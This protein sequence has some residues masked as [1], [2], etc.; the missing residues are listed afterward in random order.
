MPARVNSNQISEV[1]FSK[2][3]KQSSWVFVLPG[4]EFL[5]T[6]VEVYSTGGDGKR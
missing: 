1:S 4:L 3:I 6:I 2:D 5:K